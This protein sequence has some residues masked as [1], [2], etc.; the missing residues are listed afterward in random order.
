M[1]RYV[2]TILLFI[3]TQAMAEVKRYP[4]PNRAAMPI[5]KA[6]EIPANATLIY[7]SGMVATPADLTAESS[8]RAFWGENTEIQTDSLFKAMEK[9]LASMGLG[10]GDIVEM[11]V[12][13][14]GVPELEGR[15]D[16]AGFMRAYTNY[17]GTQEQ[18][19]RPARSTVQVAALAAPNVLV[20]I[21]VVLVRPKN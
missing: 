16:F 8:S 7:H 9:S 1:F 4:F 19:N 14:V 13:L 21:E 6:V 3:S 10:L 15:L 20:E 11:T 2:F 17:F 5:A 18:P 12:F